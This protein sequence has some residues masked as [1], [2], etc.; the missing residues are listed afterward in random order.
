[1]TRAGSNDT[2]LDRLADEGHVTN[3][4][5][6]LMARTFVLPLQGLVLDIAKVGGITMLY[7]EH[8]SQHVEAL[9]CGLALVDDDGIVKVATLDEIRLQ[10][11][12][13]VTNEDKR[14]GT[15]YLG[16]VCLLTVE[17]RKLAVDE[18]RLE[19]AHRCQREFLI[20]QDGDA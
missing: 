11:R 3:H 20:G 13:D 8:I 16:D 1:M 17:C 7:V 4:V 18:L 9:L 2:P 14:T 5:E 12:L 19:G 10:Q 15:G 6:Q